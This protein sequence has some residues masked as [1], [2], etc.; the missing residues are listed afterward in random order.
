MHKRI[1]ILLLAAA[2]SFV[3]GCGGSSTAPE[4]NTPPAFSKMLGSSGNGTNVSCVVAM[5]DGM[6]VVVGEANILNI[7]GSSTP[8]DGTGTSGVFFAGVKPDGGIGFRTFVP[9]SGDIPSIFAMARD[10]NNNLLVTGHFRNNL[11]FG[12]TSLAHNALSDIFIAKLDATA[13]PVWVQG[14]GGTGNDEGFDIAAASD[15]SVYV[16]GIVDG[17]VLIAGEDTG[18]VGKASGY[19]VKIEPGGGGAWR[20]TAT[21]SGS[22]DC[23]GVAVS[24]DGS[25]VVGGNYTG[26]EVGIGGVIL[27]NDGIENAFIARFD[28][29]G[30]PLGNI[31]LGGT[32]SIVVTAVTTIGDEVVAAGTLF[33]TADFDVNTSAGVVAAVGS[34]A[35]VARYTK[36]GQFRWAQTFGTTGDQVAAH[37]A[38]ISSGDILVCGSFEKTFSA[39]STLLSPIGSFDIFVVRLSGSGAVL[40]VKRVGGSGE[41]QVADIASSNNAL[42]VAGTSSSA[43]LTFPDGTSRAPFGSTDGFLYRQP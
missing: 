35:F 4:D 27:P 29:S 12:T 32:G 43:Q 25:V 16:C 18:V 6:S 22:A 7:T 11:T 34:D 41:E 2:V 1:S 14:A 28:A 37:L 21:P 42:I 19:L 9:G 20:Q 40:A 17:K 36:T 26:T 13:H 10:A 23:R 30:T 31:R 15:G 24:Q 39:G 5:S 8:L 33:G 3:V 38:R